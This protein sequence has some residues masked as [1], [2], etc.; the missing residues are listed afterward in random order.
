M[1]EVWLDLGQTGIKVN[2]VVIFDGVLLVWVGLVLQDGATKVLERDRGIFKE[3]VLLGIEHLG[4]EETDVVDEE[5]QHNHR[6]KHVVS[7]LRVDKQ[8]L[9]RDLLNLI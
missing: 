9:C 2:L 7:N 6:K 3:W 1:L 5:H 4:H 8:S